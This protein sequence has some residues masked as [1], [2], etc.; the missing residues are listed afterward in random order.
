MEKTVEALLKQ[1]ESQEEE[2]REE[3]Q[4]V[5]DLLAQL[6]PQNGQQ[7]AVGQQALIGNSLHKDLSDRMEKFTFDAEENKTFDKWYTRYQVIFETNAATMTAPE[8]VSM[9]C[10]KLASGDYEKFANTIL[11][12]TVA[13]IEFNTAVTTLKR[14]FG[15]KES[16]FALRY[17]CLKLEKE[18]IEDY[19]EYAARVNLKCEKFDVAH[20]TPE[21]FKVLMF[22]KGLKTAKDGHALAKLLAKLDQQEALQA[23]RAPEAAAIPNMTLQEAVNLATRLEN[24]L[25]EK[26]MVATGSTYQN[27][28][29]AVKKAHW[30]RSKHSELTNSSN[31]KPTRNDGLPPTPCYGCGANHWNNDC[32]FKDKQCFDCKK[33]GH[34]AGHCAKA[35]KKYRYSN[36]RQS[37]KVTTPFRSTRKFVEPAIADTKFRLLFDSGS[38]WTI[39]SKRNWQSLGSP[40]LHDCEEQAL[41][42]SGDPVPMLGR[43]TARLKLHGRE[44]TGSCYVTDSR[45]NVFGNDWM[46]TLGLWDV[47]I[48]SVCNSI[49]Q[50]SPNLTEQVKS[51]FPNL[52]KD[53]L[54][55]CN[56]TKA[57]L[58]LKEDARPVYRNK[59]PV[60]FAAAGPVEDELKRLQLLGVITQI[61][62]SKYAAPIVVVK[63]SNGKIRICADYST[64][65]NDSLEPNK[66][67]LPTQEA[68]FSK[69]SRFK[70]FSKIDLSDAFLQVE[71]DDDAKKLMPINTH[72]GLFQV[73]RLQPGIKTAPSIFQQ[74]IDTM[75]AGAEGA[76]PYMDDFIVGGINDKEHDTNL[77]E[78]LKRIQDYG[79]RLK[80]EKCSFGQKKIEFLG[81]IIDTN[82]IRPSPD[83][84][85]TLQNIPPPADVQQLQAFL[86]AVTWYSKFIPSLKD[87]RGPLDELLCKEIDFEWRAT[88]QTA[89]EKLKGVLA[90]DLALTHY[91][92]SKKLIV[93]ADASSYGMGAVLMHEMTDGTQRPIIHASS[94]FTKAE[95]NYP[96]IQREALALKFAVTKFHRFIYGRKFEL[97]TDHQPLL[98]IFGSKEGIPVYTASRLQRYALVLLAYDF[99]IKYIN[100]KSFA[101]ADFI[102]RLIANHDK[103]EEDVVI[104]SIERSVNA[105]KFSDKGALMRLADKVNA[106]QSSDTSAP[107]D[108]AKANEKEQVV[109][110]SNVARAV[111]IR[112]D[113]FDSGD[114][115]D[116]SSARCFAIDTAHMLPITFASIQSATRNCP[117]LTQVAKYIEQGWP[118]SSKQIVDS[119][120]KTFSYRRNS[121]ITIQGCIFYGDRI[122]IPKIHQKRILTELHSGHPGTVR[123]KLLA[124]SKVFWPGIDN[125]IEKM[126]KSCDNCASN[127]KSPAKC[128]LRSWPIPKGP[129]ERIH[130]DF[131]GP[132][133]GDYFF[134]IV[135]AFSKWPEIFKMASTTA[136][137]TINSLQEAFSRQGLCDTLVSDNGPQF[138]SGE[139]KA[140]CKEYGIEHLTSAPYHP[141]SNGQAERFVDLLKTGLKKL[142]GD[143]NVDNKLRKFLTCYR[144]TPSYSLGMKSPF[145]LMTGRDMKTKLDLMKPHCATPITRNEK[146]EK[147]Y[148]AQHGAKWKEFQIGDLVYFK[149]YSGNQRKWLP[150][151]ITM[152]QGAVNYT[153]KA[154]TPSGERLIKVHANQLKKRYSDDSHDNNIL[155]DMFDILMPMEGEVE[156]I[157]IPEPEDDVFE[158]AQEEV[159]EE[160]EPIPVIP[161]FQ[162][163]RTTRQNAGV[164]PNPIYVPIDFRK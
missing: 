65:L 88:H 78:V 84:L 147:Q 148:N 67:P 118:G 35:T 137:K 79:F 130:V 60:S 114:I 58:T 151:V 31:S 56:K 100:T 77:Y 85:K 64:G 117:V 157:I 120:V 97:Q 141:Q 27:E 128:E 122:I 154:E 133:N 33:M 22:V 121:L 69:M 49:S 119:A 30:S 129:W 66:Y 72:C 106:K 127:A 107:S 7:Q 5:R 51:D 8:R 152:K 112:S 10:E 82:G 86:G 109:P 50:S 93:A 61:D 23:Q 144:Y 12:L 63:K 41:S 68:I 140:F 108:I 150:A 14:I 9:L 131:A 59:R 52:F 146:M 71:L 123:M 81:H 15:R 111:G 42:A 153:V 28:V 39:I 103:P 101:Y 38:D 21:D 43:F 32:P 92:P 36:R 11:P 143:G 138:T 116:E 113:S 134:V 110:N 3:R 20:L 96:Q 136:S 17:Q 102:S 94:S 75:M 90:S 87:L 34:K 158:D 70:V 98:A 44:G 47:P 1:L 155:M 53:G 139:F 142:E 57:S 40:A 162:P 135:D 45:L 80:I 55:L 46:E 29:F 124:R 83:K 163:R 6:A 160:D 126:V 99:T 105:K 91:D 54:G 26:E 37:V 25:A 149:H 62:F 145:K 24:L 132:V 2:R 156:P 4:L 164:P 104:A 48:A 19:A 161:D 18:D 13:T 73:N 95:K 159:D 16:L 89:F 76:F 115:K 125:D 74:L